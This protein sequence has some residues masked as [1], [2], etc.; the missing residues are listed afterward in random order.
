MLAAHPNLALFS[1]VIGILALLFLVS[2]IERRLR[3]LRCSWC[4][5]PYALWWRAGGRACRKD[6]RRLDNISRNFRRIRQS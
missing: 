6:K 1:L 2:A 5:K 4:A 3:A